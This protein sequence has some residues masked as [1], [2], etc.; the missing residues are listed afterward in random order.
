MLAFIHVAKTGGQ[1]V[2][3]LLRGTYGLRYVHAEP[4]AAR[5]PSQ[6]IPRYTPD[7]LRRLR[8]IWPPLRAIGGH[9][10]ALWSDFDEVA[11]VRWFAFLREPLK[12]AASHYQFHV[13]TTE[14]P[15]S[16]D[17]WL[18]WDVPRNHQLR[19]FSRSIDAS[20][21]IEAI[22]REGVFIGLQER[23]DESLVMLRKLVAP[24]LR[25]D[26]MRTNTAPRNDLARGLLADPVRAEQLAELHRDEFPFYE[27]V[28]RTVYPRQQA[29]YGPTLEAD[30][31][32]FRARVGQSRPNALNDRLNR[33]VRRFWIDPMVHRLRRP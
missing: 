27:Y 5:D 31:E 8:R 21:A 15:L 7:D 14:S 23:F 13:H 25:I 12:R 17:E 18:A 24:E 16:I 26:Y 4:W 22:E 29:A 10:V 33:A 20:E 11:P 32:A 30:V 1:T 6:V 2:E 9:A 3:T 19:S 28:R